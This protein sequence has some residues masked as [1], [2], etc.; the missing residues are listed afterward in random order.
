MSLGPVV[1]AAAADGKHGHGI[2]RGGARRSVGA[3][4]A[5]GAGSVGLVHRSRVFHVT[6]NLCESFIGAR[7][8]G[9]K[10]PKLGARLQARPIRGC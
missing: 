1:S 6:H 9:A 5:G 7:E 10:R 3:V 8:D 4:V 2:K